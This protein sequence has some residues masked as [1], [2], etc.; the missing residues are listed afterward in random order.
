LSASKLIWLAALVLF[1]G[2]CYLMTVA[3]IG[4]YLALV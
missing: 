2:A 3:W 4:G 1:L